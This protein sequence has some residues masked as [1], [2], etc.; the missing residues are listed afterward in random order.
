MALQACALNLNQAKRELQSHGT[1]GFPCAGYL[2]QCANKPDEEIPWHYHEEMEFILITSG[3]LLVKTTQGKYSIHS[4]E[5]IWINAG[6]LHYAVADP[7]C[8]LHSMV[9]SS[10]L[11][12]GG[13]D[14]SISKKYIEPL[15]HNTILNAVTFNPNDSEQSKLLLEFAESFNELKND[16]F[17]HEVTVTISLSKI[18]MYICRNHPE[19]FSSPSEALPIDSVRLQKMLDYIHSHISEPIKITDLAKLLGLS[20]RETIRCFERVLHITPIQYAL[21][22]RITQSAALL[23]TKKNMSISDIAYKFGF[24]NPSYYSKLFF[25]YFQC[26]PREYRQRHISDTKISSSIENDDV[27]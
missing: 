16:T 26:T 11:I 22:Y 13:S 15:I 3:T 8:E 6:V 25:R 21:K 20:N 5:G 2:T 10:R 4:G 14:S 17:G 24:D 1:Y 18:C 7:S 27:L 23:I 19:I 9:F 12:T